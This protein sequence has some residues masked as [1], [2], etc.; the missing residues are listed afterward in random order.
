M[1]LTL[2]QFGEILTN[3][4]RLQALMAL[5]KKLRRVS[6]DQLLFVG[7]STIARY[8]WCAMQSGYRA[9]ED[10]LGSFTK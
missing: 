2:E 4:S 5:A 9:K 8:Y 7:P 1:S 10:E 3:R 6:D